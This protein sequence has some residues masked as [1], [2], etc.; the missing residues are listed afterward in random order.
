LKFG[1][2]DNDHFEELSYKIN[3]SRGIE[4]PRVGGSNPSPGTI[5][6]PYYLSVRLCAV[7]I[8][9]PSGVMVASMS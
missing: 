3:E 2:Q 8:V 6:I 9:A 7:L 1:R 4:N 5:Y